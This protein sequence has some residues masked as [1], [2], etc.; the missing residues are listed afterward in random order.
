MHRKRKGEALPGGVLSAAG[1]GVWG[2]RAS[3]GGALALSTAK[4][5]QAA[6]SSPGGTAAIY[7]TRG[8]GNPEF[9]RSFSKRK[10]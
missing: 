6:P 7:H 3:G 2:D 8:H 10:F 9:F 4:H 5:T 1:D